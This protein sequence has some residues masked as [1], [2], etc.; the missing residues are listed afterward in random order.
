MG[1]KE[2]KVTKKDN[3]PYH[4][5][6]TESNELKSSNI[7]ETSSGIITKIIKEYQNNE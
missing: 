5:Y 4:T 1:G 6:N 7:T 3:I 2:S